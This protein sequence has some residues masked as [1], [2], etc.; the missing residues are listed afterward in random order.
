MLADTHTAAGVLARLKALGV[1]LEIDDF[2]TGYSALSYLDRL[3]LDALKIDR[4]FTRRLASQSNSTTVIRT[5]L[6]LGARLGLRVIAE[7]IETE[8]QVSQLLAFGCQNG[9]GYLFGRP[10]TGDDMDRRLAAELEASA[11]STA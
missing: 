9:Q 8:D 1:Q 6:G 4:S 3:D 11:P 10:M 2:G 5:I 7:G